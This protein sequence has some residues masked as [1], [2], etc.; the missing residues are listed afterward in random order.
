MAAQTASKADYADMAELDIEVV[1]RRDTPGA[2]V[3]E[4]I[5]A[6]GDGE[7]YMAVF[8][9]PAAKDRAVEYAS[10]KYGHTAA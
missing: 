7:I 8:S 2:W 9:G 4:A 3:V 10:M 1:E 6:A 5:N